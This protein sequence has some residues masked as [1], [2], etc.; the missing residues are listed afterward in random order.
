MGDEPWR[1]V[2]RY[3]D[4][5]LRRVLSLIAA[6]A[7]TASLAACSDDSGGADAVDGSLFTAAFETFDGEQVTLADYRGTPV[8]VNFFASW[9]TPCITEMPE[10]ESVHQELG[11]RVAIIG[12]HYDDTREK[13]L[14]I[15]ERTGVTYLV[16][17][18]VDGTLFRATKGV[19]MPTTVFIRD[20]G[21]VAAVRSIALNADKL[22]DAISKELGVS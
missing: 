9:C 19:A 21:T 20:D 15:V 16:G 11:D 17:R 3:G 10:F 4:R 14:E 2:S 1:K 12:L 5:V 13:G 18:D 6:V 7:L 8:V 22:R